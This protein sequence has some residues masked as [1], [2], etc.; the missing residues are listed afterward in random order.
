M[1]KIIKACGVLFL[2]FHVQLY[3]QTFEHTGIFSSGGGTAESGTYTITG[4]LGEPIQ[5]NTAEAGPYSHTGGFIATLD[6]DIEAPQ[7]VHEEIS[8]ISEDQAV[9]VEAEITDA[10]GVE[11]AVLYYRQGGEPG[12]ESETMTVDGNLYAGTIPEAEVTS[13]GLEYFIIAT[14]LAGRESRIP[15]EGIIGVRVEV[16]NIVKP[17]AQPGGSEQNAYRLISL[18]LDVHNQNASSVLEPVLGTYNPSQW[19]LF[20]LGPDQSYTEFPN[21]SPMSPGN[22]FWLIV[23][24]SG[25]HIET[26]EGLSNLTDSNFNI[27]LQEGWTLIGNPFNFSFSLDNIETSDGQPLDIRSF[28]GS[29]STQ[30]SPLQPF[31]GY[32]VFSETET[33]MIFD[34][35]HSPGAAKPVQKMVAPSIIDEESMWGIQIIAESG[36]ARDHDNY[37]LVHPEASEEWDIYDRP[38]PPVIGEYVMVYFPHPEWEKTATTYSTDARPHLID[39]ERWEF[40]VKS[41]TNEEVSVLFDKLETVPPEFSVQLLDPSRNSV[42]DLRIDNSY[43]IA[44]KTD[45]HPHRLVL[46]VGDDAYIEEHLAEYKKVPEEFS[47]AQN[48]PNPFNPSTTIQFG[49]PRAERLSL[50]VY[51]LLGREVITLIDGEQYEAGYHSIEWDGR[52]RL[53]NEISSGTYIYQIRAGE[54]VRTKRMIYLK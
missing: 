30:T 35:D 23:R 29:W 52:N 22:A 19:R 49:L 1:L 46:L 5:G 54:H 18:P 4:V 9:N 43:R 34:P 45:E 8:V 6:I 44:D 42:L 48:Y 21:T 20:E 31:T 25:I 26:G 24:E 3:T 37:A 12:F 40:K 51:D 33:E 41:N 17:N 32:A 39:G 36:D 2:F 28:T 10:T 14:D 38:N 13:R 15:E 16:E 53:G 7:I 47:L 27:P 50:V 11:S